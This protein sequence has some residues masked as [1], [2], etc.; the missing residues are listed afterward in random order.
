MTTK[1]LIIPCPTCGKD[2]ARSAK[3]CPHCGA[4]PR[5]SGGWWWRIAVGIIVLLLLVNSLSRLSSQPHADAAANSEPTKAM[6]TQAE[7]RLPQC[8][9]ADAVAAATTTIEN[10]PDNPNIKCWPL[11]ISTQLP[12]PFLPGCY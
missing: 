11:R 7:N 2:I 9:A 12:F 6:V 1:S 3:T 10:N 5:K 4:K 8:G